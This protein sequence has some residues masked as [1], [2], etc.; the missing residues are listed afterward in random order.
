MNKLNHGFAQ[1]ITQ[2]TKLADLDRLNNVGLM[3]RQ[4]VSLDILMKPT[5]KNTGKKR[6]ASSHSLRTKYNLPHAWPWR[7]FLTEMNLDENIS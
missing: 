2:N 4:H 3:A 7:I 6:S 1:K 5:L